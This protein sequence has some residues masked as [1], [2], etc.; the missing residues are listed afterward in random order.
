MG[1]GTECRANGAH[2]KNLTDTQRLADIYT[3]TNTQ[4]NGGWQALRGLIRVGVGNDEAHSW[5]YCSPKRGGSPL[6]CWL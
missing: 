3:H 4:R 5:M 2:R 6:R 1:L